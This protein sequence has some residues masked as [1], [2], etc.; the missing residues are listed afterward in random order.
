M[1]AQVLA[2]KLSGAEEFHHASIYLGIRPKML[3]GIIDTWG[4]KPPCARWIV[5]R[6]TGQWEDGR[7]DGGAHGRRMQLLEP[8]R[9]QAAVYGWRP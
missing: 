8:L 5:M 6:T 1:F 4:K 7:G 9:Q 2:R 3:E